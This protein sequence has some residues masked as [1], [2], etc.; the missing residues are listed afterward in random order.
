MSVVTP[1][2]PVSYRNLFYIPPVTRHSPGLCDDSNSENNGPV[3][4]SDQTITQKSRL[5][6]LRF[7]SKYLSH[8]ISWG[9]QISLFYKIPFLQKAE[10]Q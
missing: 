3:F 2:I 9:V 1:T 8:N 4:L 5:C 10:R 7:Q 6:Y